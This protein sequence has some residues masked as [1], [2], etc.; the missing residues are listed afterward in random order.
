MRGLLHT[1]SSWNSFFIVGIFFAFSS[2]KEDGEG[3]HCTYTESFS[4]DGMSSRE[5]LTGV[6]EASRT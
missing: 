1:C 5:G 4:C 2:E 3:M 6:K